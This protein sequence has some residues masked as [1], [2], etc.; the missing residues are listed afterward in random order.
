MMDGKYTDDQIEPENSTEA[1][2]QTPQPDVPPTNVPKEQDD[3]EAASQATV[4]YSQ[5]TP[6]LKQRKNWP[7]IVGWTFL[8]LIILG[9]LGAGGWWYVNR[10]P[11]PKPAQNNQQQ[12]QQQSNTTAA[13]TKHYDSTDLG[14][15]FD[16]PENWTVADDNGKLTV[17]SPAMQ[18]TDADGQT[19]TG[20]AVMTI[21]SAN[22]ADFSM[23]QKG[24]AVAVLASEKVAYT[25]PTSTQ[26]ADTYI[27]F[28][29]YAATTAHGALDGV[30]VTGDYGYKYADGITE[31]D[32]TK[33]DPD[34][35]VTFV[36]CANAACTGTLTSLSIS[37]D[38]WSNK[39]FSSP[40]E[41][42]LKSLAIQ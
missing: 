16:Y 37:S 17:T 28:L 12:T 8:A 1:P 35:R 41:D 4:D 32:I 14:L 18:L 26:R 23:F 31:A 15:G 36:K 10:K 38:M 5:F 27:S 6:Q 30:Y 34:I 33:V 13:S 11:S 40:I 9:G 3:F 42:M 21:Q 19:Q 2:T 22:A 29:Q 20:Q 7:R 39:S 25:K 24:P